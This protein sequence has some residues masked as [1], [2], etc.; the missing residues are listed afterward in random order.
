VSDA[1]AEEAA[2]EVTTA[3]LAAA[4]DAGDAF[5]LDVR[6]P[7][8]YAAGRVPGVHLLPLNELAA[9]WEAEIPKDQRIWVICAVG[10]RSVTAAKALIGAGI[11]AVSVAGGTRRWAEEGRE[12][13]RG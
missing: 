1:P 4:R 9:R 3:E 6:R 12:I 7:D 13:E 8:E 2:P 11:D 10:G 5:V